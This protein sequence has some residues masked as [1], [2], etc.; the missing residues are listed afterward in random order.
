MQKEALKSCFATYVFF[1][2]QLGNIFN[3]TSINSYDLNWTLE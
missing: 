1:I 3:K 2:T